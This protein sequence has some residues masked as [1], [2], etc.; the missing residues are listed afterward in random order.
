MDPNYR[1]PF[2]RWVK[3]FPL[4]QATAVLCAKA[5]VKEVSHCYGVP[6]KMISDNGVQFIS[7]VIQQVCKVLNIHQLLIPLHHPEA[8]PVECRNRDL[9]TQ[10]ATLVGWDQTMRNATYD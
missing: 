5:L 2:F 7:A 1:G 8:N 10:L 9:K 4:R 6:R 3:L